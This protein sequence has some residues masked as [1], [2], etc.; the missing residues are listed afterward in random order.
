[1]IE[2]SEYSGILPTCT[3]TILYLQLFRRIAL[4][5]RSYLCGLGISS[6]KRLGVSD[7]AL[8]G[9]TLRRPACKRASM[10]ERFRLQVWLLSLGAL[11]AISPNRLHLRPPSPQIAP[12]GLEGLTVAGPSVFRR[13]Y[14]GTVYSKEQP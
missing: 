4:K 14:T 12:W 10:L 1:M 2:G 11:N 9:N 5:S 6:L 3:F 8:P 13:L 7:Q